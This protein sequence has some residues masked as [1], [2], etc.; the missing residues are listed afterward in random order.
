MKKEKEINKLLDKLAEKNL[1]PDKALIGELREKLEKENDLSKIANILDA[2][3]GKDAGEGEL[4]G[5]GSLG[6]VALSTFLSE[7][8]QTY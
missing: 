6:D 1:L 2:L 5:D 3:E 8:N 7:I 4:V